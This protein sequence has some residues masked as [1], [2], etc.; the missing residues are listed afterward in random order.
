MKVG[1][2]EIKEVSMRPA[3]QPG[4]TYVGQRSA[5]FSQGHPSVNENQVAQWM[6][7]LSASIKPLLA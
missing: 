5:C 4:C 3:I 6:D 1:V 7:A 2:C